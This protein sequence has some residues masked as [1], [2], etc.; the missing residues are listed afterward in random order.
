[1]AGLAVV[2]PGFA[3][4]HESP[5]RRALKASASAL[6]CE[7]GFTS[8]DNDAL[9]TIIEMLQSGKFSSLTG[10]FFFSNS[11]EKINSSLQLFIQFYT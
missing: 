6:L 7:V 9:E 3:H 11:L 1:M 4:C 10:L 8:A 5:Y 2:D